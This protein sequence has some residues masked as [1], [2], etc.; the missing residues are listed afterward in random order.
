MDV[1]AHQLR[2]TA[3]SLLID[4]GANA[5]A[6]QSFVGHS[7]IRMTL[8]TYRHLFDHGG[9]ALA[10]I[11]EGLREEHRNGSTNPQGSLRS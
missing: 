10:D 5:R 7:D 9:A 6:I 8:G 11:M 3:V 4:A 2:H 1:N